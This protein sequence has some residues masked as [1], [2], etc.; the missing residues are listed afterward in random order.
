MS[1]P[2]PTS[3]K[4]VN[5]AFLVILSTSAVEKP[6]TG[7]DI[8]TQ[9][10]KFYVDLN[11]YITTYNKST[12]QQNIIAGIGYVVAAVTAIFAMVIELRD[13]FS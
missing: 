4:T 13:F 7:V 3:V 1:M 5:P 6:S 8:E 9:V 11:K 10:R 2:N 12:R